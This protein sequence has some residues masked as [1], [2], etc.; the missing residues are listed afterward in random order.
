MRTSTSLKR[1]ILIGTALSA[2]VIVCAWA[3]G[4]PFI[5]ASAPPQT[6]QA[7]SQAQSGSFTGTIERDGEQFFLRVTSGPIYRLDD[8]KDAQPLEGKPVTVVGRL[9]PGARTIHVERIAPASAQTATARR[10]PW[11]RS[12]KLVA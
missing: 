2:F 10:P 1:E 6:A 11:A 8:P 3:W 9:D 12:H 4:R 7:Q 5:T